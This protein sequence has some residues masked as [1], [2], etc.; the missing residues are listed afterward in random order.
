MADVKR[1]ARLAS[2]LAPISRMHVEMGNAQEILVVKICG[3]IGL[4]LISVLQR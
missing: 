3:R 1:V 2:C 4:I